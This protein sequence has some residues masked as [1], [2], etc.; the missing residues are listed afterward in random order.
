MET[1]LA[2]CPVERS[3]PVSNTIDPEMMQL[4]R[5]IRPTLMLIASLGLFVAGYISL[6]WGSV[7]QDGYSA[8]FVV[9]GAS[10]YFVSLLIAIRSNM[11]PLVAVIASLGVILGIIVL[12]VCVESFVE[13]PHRPWFPIF[14][15]AV[16]AMNCVVFARFMK[17]H[18]EGDQA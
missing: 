7:I 13:N 1:S 5:P 6:G 9:L 2:A 18:K 14:V 11:R 4:A 12:F 3:V 16:L 17:S 15:I 8:G 10:T